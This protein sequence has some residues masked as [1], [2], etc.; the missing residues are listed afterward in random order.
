MVKCGGQVKVLDTKQWS[1]LEKNCL[2]QVHQTMWAIM[3]FTGCRSCE[4]RFL[5]V[6]NV[7][8]DPVKG[9]VRPEIF[10]PASIR[11]GKKQSLSV[12]VNSTLL[13]YLEL[14]QPP[15]D[16]YLFPSP[17]NPEQPISYEAVYKY[18]KVT[19]EKAGLSHEKIG[20]HSGRRS[21]ITNLAKQGVHPRV[22]QT[23]SGHQSLSSLQRYI[24]VSD[25]QKV[26][27]LESIC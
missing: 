12:P 17:R 4:V 5:K 27:A 18:L 14:Y 15:T 9:I 3:R 19:A 21:L 24:E 2:S 26:N 1:K 8:S 25:A 13:S 23:I 7:Y 11:K 6:E 20:T 16:G 10:F 22:I